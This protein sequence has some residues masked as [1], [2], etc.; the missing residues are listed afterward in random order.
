P[1]SAFLKQLAALRN[2]PPE[3]SNR[4]RFRSRVIDTCPRLRYEPLVIASAAGRL[5]GYQGFVVVG[6]ESGHRHCLANLARRF[7]V[8]L[9][10]FG[11]V[12][13]LVVA[14]FF[15]MTTLPVASRAPLSVYRITRVSLW[16]P[17]SLGIATALLA[18]PGAFKSNFF[19]FGKVAL[20]VVA[21]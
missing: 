1:R 2:L 7:Q 6:G 8:Q 10:P 21:E 13:L 12:A 16:F 14:E 18:L 17:A 11:K 20:P 4:A 5:S 15:F 9:L 19:A 3:A